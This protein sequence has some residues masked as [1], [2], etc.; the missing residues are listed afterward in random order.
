M[1]I[2]SYVLAAVIVS[3]FAASAPADLDTLIEV[4]RGQ[5]EIQK[6]YNEEERAYRVVRQAIGSGAL[7]KGTPRAD[8]VKRFGEPVVD[9]YD[10]ERGMQKSI[11]KPAAS[12]FFGGEQ[13][14]VF[15]NDKG[16]VEDVVFREETP[17]N[18]EG[19]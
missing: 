7:K 4:G 9:F 1:N 19:G 15:F 10:S 18:K 5:A 3:G 6:H 13:I 17:E 11:Y 8:I 2:R 12:S 16:L 14:A